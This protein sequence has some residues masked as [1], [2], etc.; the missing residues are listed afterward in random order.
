VVFTAKANQARKSD[1]LLHKINLCRWNSVGTS[2]KGLAVSE[3]KKFAGAN[4]RKGK[5]F[6]N[7]RERRST[8]LANIDS[9]VEEKSSKGTLSRGIE[10][11]PDLNKPDARGKGQGFKKKIK[12]HGKG[13]MA[14]WCRK[15]KR[16][17]RKSMGPRGKA[18]VMI[19]RN[20]R[21]YVQGERRRKNRT[22]RGRRRVLMKT[23]SEGKRGVPELW[24]GTNISGFIPSQG[25]PEYIS[26]EFSKE[27]SNKR[28]SKHARERIRSSPEENHAT[29]LSTYEVTRG[30][31]ERSPKIREIAADWVIEN[32]I[33]GFKHKRIT[34]RLPH[35]T[36]DK[37]R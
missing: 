6:S 34:R 9:M 4:V 37:R 15:K 32:T 26:W 30:R 16:R 22:N 7:W 20:P 18:K 24:G 14:L 21:V 33:F 5:S 19:A 1:V 23:F 25:T 17:E 13:S 10:N 8:L 31:K 35:Y 11:Q 29:E 27:R 3:Q 36:T 12:N 28:A 2:E